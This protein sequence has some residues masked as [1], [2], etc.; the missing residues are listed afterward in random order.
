[1]LRAGADLYGIDLTEYA[2]EQTRRR[3]E[4]FNLASTLSV[5]YAEKLVF[6]DESFDL[7]CSWG[8]LHNSPDTPQA[9][10][11]VFFVFS[12]GWDAK[13]RIYHKR[14]MFGYMLRGRY[15]LLRFWITLREIYAQYL[16]SLGTKSYSLAEARQLF[17]EFRDVII[18]TPLGHGDLLKSNM[19]LRHR[20]FLLSMAKSLGLGGLFVVLCRS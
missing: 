15:A 6:P 4:I 3:F 9:V 11:K 17:S 8:M 2:V 7:V 18:K 19:R 10:S 5:G 13:I 20:Y 14:S 12:R 16:E 1:M